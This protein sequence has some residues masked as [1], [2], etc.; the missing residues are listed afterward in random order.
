MK[1]VRISPKIFGRFTSETPLIIPKEPM[2]VVYGKNESGKTTYLDMTVALLASQYDT[3][4]ME[5][6]GKRELTTFSGSIGIQ[7]N[8]ED[9]TVT[10]TKDAKVPAARSKVPRTPD[11]KQSVIWDKIKDLQL[12]T[13]RNLFRVSSRDISNGDATLEKFNQYSL[14]DRSGQSVTGA[15]DLLKERA[16][17]AKNTVTSLGQDLTGFKDELD[18]VV[19][20][21]QEYKDALNRIAGNSIKVEEKKNKHNWSKF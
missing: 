10:F 15:L 2:V 16:K 1:I 11:P 18:K 7:E 14:G 21:A 19:G 9:L 12:D 20:T 3:A 6:Y 5:R 17:T 8:G 4:L 13:V